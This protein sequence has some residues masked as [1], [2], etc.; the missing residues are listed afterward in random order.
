M[1]NDCRPF[2]LLVACWASLLLPVL[3]DVEEWAGMLQH[4]RRGGAKGD[5]PSLGSSVF[6]VYHGGQRAAFGP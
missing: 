1:S 3:D 5:I 2:A 6:R 4:W